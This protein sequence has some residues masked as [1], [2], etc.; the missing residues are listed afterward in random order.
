M[1]FSLTLNNVQH[2][3][4]LQFDI[5]SETGKMLCLVGKTTLLR[6]IRNI[7]LSNTFVETAA[8]YI[9][10]SDSSI[11]YIFDDDLYEYKYNV[12]LSTL[13]SRQV[14]PNEIKD[15]FLVELP[16]PHG[17]RFNQFLRLVELDE[18]IRNKIALGDYQEPNDLIIFLRKIYEDNRF[19]HL[20]E[21]RI[22]KLKYYFILRDENERFYI[23]EDYLS[24]G[25]YFVINLY[26][27]IKSGKRIIFIDEIDISL[28][29]IAQVNLLKALRE[30]CIQQNIF[31]VFTTHS[32]A[33][34]KTVEPQELFY[35]ELDEETR[36]VSIE[37][38]SYNFIKSLL[39]RFVGYDKYLLTE[40][41]CLEKYLHYILS[42]S[43]DSFYK[44]HVIY[45]GG[46]SQVVDLLV[47]NA[48][49]Q[50]LS[51]NDDVLA[52]LDG[53][54]K[55]ERYHQGCNNILFLPF[56]NIE[57]EILER[58]ENG[59]DLLPAGVEIDGNKRSKRAKN[60][61]WKLTKKHGEEQLM[62]MDDIYAYLEIFYEEELKALETRVLSFLSYDVC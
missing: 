16:I 61:V 60:L 22:G 62:T 5:D 53:D 58:Y 49:S 32:L 31:I 47:R 43:E 4:R 7:Y 2:I 36:E 27:N 50:F 23:R 34:M 52:V 15:L 45:I 13:D 44:Y 55:K 38:R 48:K 8:P 20:K 56:S 40:D 3:K 14:I 6:S 17:N 37:N 41:E 39:Y 11:E 10:N 35:I 59:C 51:S 54:Q 9:F 18:Q 28:D 33:L 25:E 57:M 42:K 19:E 46:G 29:S 12:K 26:R 21:V 30:I 24:S 1:K